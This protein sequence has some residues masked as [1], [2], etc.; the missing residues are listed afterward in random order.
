MAIATVLDTGLKVVG[1]LRLKQWNKVVP[2]IKSLQNGYVNISDAQLRKESLALRY[3]AK[4]GDSLEK[5]LPEAFA[6]VREASKRALGMQH[7][8]VQLLGGIAMHNHSIAEMQTGEG[9]TLTATLPMYLASLTGR[10]VHLA[11]ANDYLAR[12]DAEWMGPV[13]RM[14]GVSVGIV[15]TQMPRA[16]R[17]RS[18]QSDV[19]YGTA[20]EFG[21]DFL[22]D[23]LLL[24][25]TVD[26][27]A[28]LL[29]GMLGQNQNVGGDK[30]I[31][32]DP[33]FCL[34]DEADSLL[35][36][37]A[38]TPL[39]ISAMPGEDYNTTIQTYHW[40][41]ESVDRYEEDT[42]YEYDYQK[43]TVTLNADGRRMVRE[44]AKP[45]E[46]AVVGMFDLY[47]HTERAIKV[48]R[49]FLLDRHYV[50]R[51]GEIVIVDEFTGR[52][53]E[54]RKWR[55]GIHQ[56]IEAKEDVEITVE[57]NQ[58]ARITV[59]DYFL[60]Y[61]RLAGMTGTAADSAR[62]LNK[63]YK[64]S[65][66]AVPTNR[67]AQRKRFR[68]SVY[69]TAEAKYQAIVDEVLQ[70]HDRGRPVLI[71]TRS[72]DKSE[73][74]AELLRDRGVALKV[75]NANNLPAEAEIVKVAGEKGKITVATN[76]AGRGTD[77]KLGKGVEQIDGLHVICTELHDSARID[78]QLIGRCGRQGDPGT[79]H[80][81]L[82]LDDDI[83]LNGLGPRKSKSLES[84]GADADNVPHRLASLFRKA[85][86]KV[87]RKYFRQRQALMH[88]EREHRK[89]QQQMGQDPYLD[90]PG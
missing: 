52:L 40:A 11:T 16:Q 88:H 73:R 53:S 48:A 13:Y 24:R 47:E 39:I 80:Q 43:K 33:Y 46:L 2:Q 87:E 64:V 45:V 90:T 31:Q 49:E 28:D 14:L 83:L 35:I 22:R 69:G 36:D 70:C 1:H 8:E 54:G 12:R 82:S 27:S 56:A 37:E 89:I 7:Y 25:R 19:T 77:I 57:T 38:R 59:Q 74:L 68:T 17:A 10:S 79:F 6:L 71:G 66:V 30:T 18:Y 86:A 9:K 75:L 21:F 62:E 4:S 15:E 51:D 42:H 55:A 72:I 67:P 78:R 63:I 32:R 26:G 41:A 84:R 3:R 61:E 44:I 76:M 34:V 5:L 20:K 85:Q 65:F 60:R 58:A 50:V 81:F 23:R 29:G